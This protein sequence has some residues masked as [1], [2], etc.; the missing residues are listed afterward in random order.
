MTLKPG[1][2][3]ITIH[4]LP[5]ISWSKGNKTMKFGQPIEL[6]KGN[7]FLQKSCGKWDRGTSSRPLFIDKV[8]ARGR[9]LNF[10]IFW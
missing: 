1:E 2:K 8:K 4:E 5:N 9:K 10:N 7:V 6:H 3:T